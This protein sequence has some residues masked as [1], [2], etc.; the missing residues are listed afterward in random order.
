MRSPLL[1]A[2]FLRKW[3]VADHGTKHFVGLSISHSH[4]TIYN[5][6]NALREALHLR[7]PVKGSAMRTN[8][9]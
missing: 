5:I 8:C 9:D 3:F 7:H 6:A 4:P 1:R 2:S